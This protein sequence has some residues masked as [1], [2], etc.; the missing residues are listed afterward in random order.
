[1]NERA[2]V[3]GRVVITGVSRGIGR[4]T[5]LALAQQDYQIIGCAR[6]RDDLEVLSQALVEL[7]SNRDP[8]VQHLLETRD[9]A[10]QVEVEAFAKTCSALRGGGVD[11]LVHNLGIWSPVRVLDTAA[12][13]MQQL[14][15]INVYTAA[16][17]TRLLLPTL[18]AGAKLVF[19]NSV[20]GIKAYP[21]G[22]AYTVT[23]HA[24][25]GLARALQLELRDSDI[26]VT[27]IFPGPVAT[28]SWT[29]EA[30]AVTPHVSAE[31]VARAVVA[32][33]G[34]DSRT[35]VHEIHLGPRA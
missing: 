14:M 25:L 8:A 9:L 33:A 24:L 4:A 31:D 19:V 3:A 30:L 7:G 6:G 21:Q 27:S 34:M 11:V 29:A 26:S 18:K 32:I 1:M 5:A 13:E 2:T 20:A 17:L 12:K 16:E 35:E 22:G 28:S 23:K 10:R 15:Q